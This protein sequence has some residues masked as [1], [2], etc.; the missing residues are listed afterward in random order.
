[1]NWLVVLMCQLCLPGPADRLPTRQA[2]RHG[3][4]QEDHLWR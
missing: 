2:G 1:M 3:R 4:R